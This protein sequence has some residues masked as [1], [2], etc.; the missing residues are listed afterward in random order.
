MKSSF[1]LFPLAAILSFALVSAL[2][3]AGG[4]HSDNAKPQSAAPAVNASI[5]TELNPGLNDASY[6]RQALLVKTRDYVVLREGAAT[7]SSAVLQRSLAALQ[8]SRIEAPFPQYNRGSLL[9]ADEFGL[10]RMFEIYYNAAIDPADA[11]RQLALNPAIEYAEPIFVRELFFRPNDPRFD[12]QYALQLI[13]A[14]RAWDISKGSEEIVIAITDSGTD[15]EHVDL[16]DRMWTN[17]G[18]DPDG[19]GEDDDNNGF[20]D[21]YRGWDF[22]GNVTL[23]QAGQGSFQPDNDPKVAKS[24]VA[25]DSRNHGTHVAGAAVAS[26]DN[27]TG[28]AAIGF[29]C[30][31]MPIKISS[32]VDGQNRVRIF[33]G[34][35]AIQY[36]AEMGADIVN[37]SWGGTN[38]SQADQDIINQATAK[39]TLVVAA[40][41]NNGLLSD[42]VPQYPANYDNVLSVGATNGNDRAAN[43]SNFGV[44]VDVWAPGVATL[45]T[46]HGNAY[47]GAGTYSGTSMASPIVAGIAG[48]IKTLHPDWTPTQIAHQIRSTVD[49]VIPSDAGN[50]ARYFGRANAFRA[51]NYNRTFTS[52]NTIPG[53]AHTAVGELNGSG[54]QSL[55]LTLRNYLAPSNDLLVSVES[56][57]EW[58]ELAQDEYLLGRVNHMEEKELALELTVHDQ[59]PWYSSRVQ[60]L[61]TYADEEYIDYELISLPLEF[62]PEG[63]SYTTTSMA[64]QAQLLALT[65]WNSASAPDLES[66]WGAGGFVQGELAVFLRSSPLQVS[67]GRLLGNDFSAKAV[68]GLNA[69]TGFL[70]A[71]MLQSNGTEIHKTVNQGVNWSRTSVSHIANEIYDIH[72]FDANEGIFIGNGSDAAWG[73]G[74]TSDGGQAWQPVTTV[75]EQSST[76]VGV[77][78]SAA[79]FEDH[80]WFGSTAGRVFHSSDRGRNWSA[81]SL[82]A[83]ATVSHLAFSSADDGI[84]IY[85]RLNP[86]PGPLLLVWTS[87]GGTTWSDDAVNLSESDLTPRGMAIEPVVA[88]AAPKREQ[89]FLLTSLATIY[90]S[91]D[92]GQSWSV[93]QTAQ[94]GPTAAGAAVEHDGGVRIW[95]V[96]WPTGYLDIPLPVNGGSTDVT[97]ASLTELT[98]SLQPNPARDEIKVVLQS[99]AGESIEISI[100]DL[101][102]R[103][104]LGPQRFTAG[105]QTT[106]PLSIESLSPG[107]YLCR[108]QS[109]ASVRT[110]SFVVRP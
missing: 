2:V 28:I 98:A 17:E 103:Q 16:S 29:N 30:R 51:L 80:I 64:T 100:L 25:N 15:W 105:D 48:L 77:A 79:N 57:S 93:L 86:N 21:D 82:S 52:G 109:A 24:L 95:S 55:S 54:Q 3:V 72:F 110:L 70:G 58:V 42:L 108:I 97:E 32:D 59:Y 65:R 18:E 50:E 49:F 94:Q 83:N 88:F 14:E 19:N 4:L 66:C 89:F 31:I 12:N 104:A 22:V 96:G 37:C 81:S 71:Q 87:D 63:K 27:A 84:A 99:L 73:L 35:R 10:G 39:G 40:A 56:L 61:L 92:K 13:E 47:S 106:I 45:S 62:D 53:I 74:L 7:F 68:F 1:P 107:V 5:P 67:N 6:L 38:F 78:G 91:T 43:F 34:Y 41:G 102:G 36:A 9:R 90:T 8:V 33:A 46:V 76:E 20:V 69:S 44:T 26:T 60:L 101:Q 23:Q 85:Q 11:C 75:P